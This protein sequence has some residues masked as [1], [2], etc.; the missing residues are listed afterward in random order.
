MN[1]SKEKYTQILIIVPTRE[2]VVQVVNAVKELTTYMNVIAVGIYGG[3]NINTQAAEVRKGVDVL[4]AT[5]GRLLDLI[6]L[7]ACNLNSVTYLVL[8][9]ADIMF[10][11]GFEP[12]VRSIM[13]QI[14]PDRQTLM[15]SATFDPKI[16]RLG[17]HCLWL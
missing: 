7:K 3:A 12:Q 9:E 14:R 4:V 17:K 6:Q 16:E 15:F 5:P 1:S 8:D 13:G 10:N 2:L 11:M